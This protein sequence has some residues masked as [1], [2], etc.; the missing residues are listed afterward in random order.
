MPTKLNLVRVLTRAFGAGNLTIG[1]CPTCHALVELDAEEA[2]E[3]WHEQE[4]KKHAVQVSAPATY[5][6]R[7][8]KVG[9]HML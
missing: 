8:I 4:A 7:P 9:R 1:T 6:T 3:W 5:E 2:H